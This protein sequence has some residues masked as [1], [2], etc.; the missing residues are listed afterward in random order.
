MDSIGS[1]TEQQLKPNDSSTSQEV[2]LTD[3][4]T[5]IGFSAQGRELLWQKGE[6]IGAGSYGKVYRC[7]DAISG[8]IIAVK[9]IKIRRGSNSKQ[10]VGAVSQE[11]KVLS[12][13]EHPNIIRYLGAEYTRSS[14]SVLRIF[15]E[16]APDGSVRDAL[17][18]FGPFSEHT[19][20]KYTKDILQGLSFLHSRRFVHRDIKPTNLL[21]HKGTV[22]LADFGC[23]VSSLA[24][25]SGKSAGLEGAVGTTIYM[26]P[27]VMGG[28][29]ASGSGDKQST[30]RGYGRK[31][32]IWSLA[33]SIIEMANAEPPFRSAAS[34]IYRVCVTKDYPPIPSHLSSDAHAFIQR[35]LVE[36]PLLRADTEE[37]MSLSFVSSLVQQLNSTKTARQNASTL[38]FNPL[39]NYNAMDS[40]E[41]SSKESSPD[42]S[43]ILSTPTV[44]R[45]DDH[46]DSSQDI[47][48]VST[49]LF[50]FNPSLSHTSPLMSTSLSSAE[51]RNIHSAPHCRRNSNF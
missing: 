14:K 47:H 30:S 20:R 4:K 46:F 6:L 11:L 16:L 38:S 18:E 24:D 32:D 12:T 8:E 42:K 44:F 15:F 43:D 27:E 10:L 3:S 37:L 39:E 49:E 31:A 13:L 7:I 28:T 22:K 36:D 25:S 41:F 45:S 40:V 35:C 9:E 23:A 1:S 48:E 5:S 34:A 50:Q 33:L 2:T 26:A 17:R 51:D 19:I 21:I 29:E